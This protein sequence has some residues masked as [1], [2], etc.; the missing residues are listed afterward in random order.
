MF[1][2]FVHSDG[3]SVKFSPDIIKRQGGICAAVTCTSNVLIGIWF[4]FSD[5]CRFNLSHAQGHETVYHSRVEC[6]ADVYVNEQDRFGG[7]LVLVWGEI[8]R[9]NKTCLIVIAKTYIND[10]LVVEAHP[11]IQFHGPNVT[12][13]HDNACSYSATITR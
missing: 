5:E 13:M 9:G 4:L 6:F 8:M 11:F 3:T 12:L 2:L 10:V 7:H 1:N